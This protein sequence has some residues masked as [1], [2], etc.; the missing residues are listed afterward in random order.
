MRSIHTVTLAAASL[1]ASA[2]IMMPTQAAAF[3]IQGL[4]RL[5]VAHS[6]GGYTPGGYTGY[7]GGSHHSVHS[8]SRHSQHSD[9]DAET[10]PK[11][12]DDSPKVVVRHPD[13]DPAPQ[14]S[15]ISSRYA[16]PAFAPS[17]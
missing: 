15:A 2:S 4:V 13:S 5:A 7:T 11:V 17:R 12:T 16:E 1:L 9:E 6:Y 10:P 3:D 8:A 14:A